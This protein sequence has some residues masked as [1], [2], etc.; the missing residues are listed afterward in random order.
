MPLDGAIAKATP[1]A[2]PR[3][4]PLGDCDHND[5]CTTVVPTPIGLGSL[6]GTHPSR[7]ASCGWPEDEPSM[8]HMRAWTEGRT[9]RALEMVTYVAMT[10]KMS[11]SKTQ[12]TTTT[13]TIGED[14]PP[15]DT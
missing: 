11:C 8:A 2:P 6:Q 3:T 7:P 15:P 10:R 14:D 12:P 13:A 9:R 5:I 1:T 4:Q